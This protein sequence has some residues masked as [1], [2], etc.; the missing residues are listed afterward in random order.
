MTADTGPAPPK[1][2]RLW[3]TGARPHTLTLAAAPVAVGTA[4]AWAEGS[5]RRG[6][7]A[8]AA[9]LAAV[10]IQ[11]GTNLHNDAADYQR[12]NDRPE[13][14][15]P[16]RITAAG[17][18]SPAEVHR[19][20]FAAFALAGLLG[21]YLAYVGGWPIVAVGLLSLLAGWAYS[22]GPRPLAYTPL[23]EVF[24]FVFFGLVAVAGSHYL[25]GG[26]LAPTAVLAGG[27]M[28]A[29]AAAV[30]TVNNGRDREGDRAA[31]RRTLAVLLGRRR[32]TIV[33]GALVLSPFPFLAAVQM[34]LPDKPWLSLAALAMPV[35]IRLTQRFAR[36]GSGAAFNA[37]L[38][39]TARIQL[40]FAALICAGLALGA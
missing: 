15:G 3:W 7:V 13:R 2:L 39:A 25:Q 38:A 33:Y 18:A 6:L 32:T 27:A 29:F 31:G 14:I 8:V 30:L 28:G 34:I 21:L 5:P 9:L 20:A 17:W 26:R 10:L 40:L 16:T 37:L 4:L 1:G 12:G 36:A 35:A 23:G 24:V 19:A 22:G 11:A